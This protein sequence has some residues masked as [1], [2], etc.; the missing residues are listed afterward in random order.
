VH[1]SYIAFRDKV[2]A[3]SRISTEAVLAARE[4]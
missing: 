4:G 1:A 2:A 3:W